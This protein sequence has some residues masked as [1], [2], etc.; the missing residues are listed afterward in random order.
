[1]PKMFSSTKELDVPA[2]RAVVVEDDQFVLASLMARLNKLNVDAVGFFEVQS[3]IEYLRKNAPDF[4]IVDIGLPDGDGREIIKEIRASSINPDMPVIVATADDNATVASEAY[5]GLGVM[6][7][8]HKP[9]EWSCL[10]Y[11]LE[12]TVLSKGYQH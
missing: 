6:L 12:S 9:I 3:A 4:A 11:V 7:V 8:S 1:M 10:E 2:A 5:E